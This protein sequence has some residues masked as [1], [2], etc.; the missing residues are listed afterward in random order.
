MKL[1]DLNRLRVFYLICSSEN[2]KDASEKYGYSRPTLSKDIAY[3]EDFYGFPLFVRKENN[4]YTRAGK[5]TREG[6]I[7]FTECKKIFD[8]FEKIQNFNPTAHVA[9]KEVLTIMTTGGLSQYWLKN[10][11]TEFL[12]IDHNLSLRVIN[13]KP[14]FDF[15]RDAIDVFI[16]GYLDSY[17][18][19]IQQEICTIEFGLFAHY[20]SNISKMRDLENQKIIFNS[21]VEINN[22]V[23]LLDFA[24]NTSNLLQINSTET[25]IN[26]IESGFGVGLLPSNINV[27]TTSNKKRVLSKEINFSDK[28]YYTVQQKNQNFQKYFTLFNFINDKK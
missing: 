8:D 22:L 16:G 10:Y 13:Y 1:I 11:L 27:N 12:K 24:P 15:E 18:D 23:N 9:E 6:E 7:L 19:L 20:D 21:K 2:M 25:V 14:N 17:E 4:G 3:L 28:I 5:L 26:L